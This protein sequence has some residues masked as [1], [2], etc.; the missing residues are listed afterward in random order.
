MN[1]PAQQGARNQK[2]QI[3]LSSTFLSIQTLHRLDDALPH[4]GGPATLLR[5]QIQ[6]L[7]SSE[8]TLTD[9]SRNKVNLGTPW[10]IEL[11]HEINHLLI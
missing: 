2:G 3:P 1:V 5:A 9:T 8:N 4:W 7:M 10:P 11:A 6:M